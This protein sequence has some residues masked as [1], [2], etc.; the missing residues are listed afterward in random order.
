[1]DEAADV[2]VVDLICGL[3]LYS[4]ITLNESLY[5][6]T[7]HDVLAQA[8]SALSAYVFL[9]RFLGLCS[10]IAISLAFWTAS[11]FDV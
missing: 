1:M 7:M 5:V 6:R 3:V 11:Q 2:Y 4:K 8:A 10:Y 9:V